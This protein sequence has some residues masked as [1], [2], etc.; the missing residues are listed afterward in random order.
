MKQKTELINFKNYGN[1]IFFAILILLFFLLDFHHILFLR[2]QGIH[3]IRQTDS[4]SFV[5][6]YYKNGMDF[7]EPQV[8][9]LNSING[10][11]A[12]E[13]PILYYITA[14]FY[15][16]FGE[17]EFFLR[18]ITITIVSSGLFF[19][20]KLLEKLLKSTAYALIFT[21]LF[22]SSTVFLYYTNNFLP[23]ASALGFTFIG[24]YFFYDFLPDR[25]NKKSLITGFLFF[26]LSSLLKVTYFI[27]PAAAILTLAACD[28]SKKTNVKQFVKKNFL[29]LSL[30]GIS[31]IILT[32]WNLFAILYNKANHD[33]YFLVS[34][35][36][37]FEMNT[38]GIKETWGNITGY[39]YTRYYSND[40]FNALFF[41][42]IAGFVFIKRSNRTIFKTT[43]FLTAGSLIF[44][45]LFFAQFKDHDYYF[46]TLI[47][48]IVF[49]TVNSF[50]A[51]QNRFPKIINN[52]ITGIILLILVVISMNYAKEKLAE[53]YDN[54][55]V[56]IFSDIGNVLSGADKEL[57]S[58]EISPESK[59][60][61]FTDKTPNG[62][63]YFIRRPGWS[64]PGDSEKNLKDL[65]KHI[66][67]GADYLLC[68]GNNYPA[69]VRNYNLIYKSEKYSLYKIK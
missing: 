42:I 65:E 3:F 9:N 29:I 62:G 20:F 69:S 7:F 21:F 41:I 45:L 50:V 17:H 13:F 25:D 24:W 64:I 55:R 58:L 43:L 40:T 6:N 44:F 5:V 63:L 59:F 57:D 35:K 68:T 27:N 4:L 28:F 51:L 37:I 36:P 61:I 66:R 47:P 56:D 54:K 30:F 16:I 22:F 67:Q 49:L 19:L 46:L 12:C 18:L 11:A 48:A 53:R 60:I 8:F 38:E 2:P 15:K 39:W 34:A 31:I 14:L 26:T 10:K 1:I 32:G 52:Y 23:D 33:N